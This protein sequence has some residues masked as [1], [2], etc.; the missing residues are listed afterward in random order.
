MKSNNKNKGTQ[1]QK[2]LDGW[3]DHPIAQKT[4]TPK[5]YKEKKLIKPVL[6]PYG[7]SSINHLQ[8]KVRRDVE[9]NKKIKPKTVFDGYTPPSKMKKK[10]KK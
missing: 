9:N 7:I 5:Q 8:F 10:T 1:G 2:R 4:K 6:D 3:G